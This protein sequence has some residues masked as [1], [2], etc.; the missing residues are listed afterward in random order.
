[1]V[2]LNYTKFVALATSYLQSADVLAAGENNLLFFVHLFGISP[3]FPWEQF[4]VSHF[5]SDLEQN[6][7]HILFFHKPGLFAEYD[8]VDLYLA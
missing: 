5:F 2:W 4:Q 8:S 1:M 3:S 6:S 7:Q